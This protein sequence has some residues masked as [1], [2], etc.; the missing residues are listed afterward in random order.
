LKH[1]LCK[2][3]IVARKIQG[4]RPEPSNDRQLAIFQ[5]AL[6]DR[7]KNGLAI[8]RKVSAVGASVRAAAKSF[9]NPRWLLRKT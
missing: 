9:G 7:L 5:V 3:R 1:D 4:P 8:A 2:S 6:G